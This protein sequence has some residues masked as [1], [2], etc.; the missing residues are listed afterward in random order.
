MKQIKASTGS[1]QQTSQLQT[2][3]SN[4]KSKQK[5]NEEEASGEQTVSFLIT[6][7]SPVLFADTILVCGGEK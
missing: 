4:T 6:N 2:E 1:L 5:E 3:V 7:K